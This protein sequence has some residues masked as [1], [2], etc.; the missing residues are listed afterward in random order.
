MTSPADVL[1]S[2]QENVIANDKT[3]AWGYLSIWRCG[4]CQRILA[5]VQLA[6]GSKLEIK[7]RSCNTFNTLSTGE[8]LG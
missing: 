2:Q 5:K 3:G 7:C 8:E 6:T 4:K 1:Q